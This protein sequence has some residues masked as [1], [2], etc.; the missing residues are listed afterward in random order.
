MGFAAG[1]QLAGSY[2]GQQAAEDEKIKQRQLLEKVLAGFQNIPL[3]D[4]SH[5]GQLDD[6]SAE[7]PASLAAQQEAMSGLGDIVKGGGLTLNDQA[8][9]NNLMNGVNRQSS[10]MMNRILEGMAAR[11]TGGSGQ[12]LAMQMQAAQNGTQRASD[13]SLQL[14]G[15]AK[16]RALDAMLSRGRLGGEISDRNLR[17]EQARREIQKFNIS[18]RDRGQQQNFNNQMA[19]QGGSASATG[20]LAGLHGANANAA[21]VSGANMGAGVGQIGQGIW[22]RNSQGDTNDGNYGYSDDYWRHS[23]SKLI[24]QED[25]K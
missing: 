3:P 12:E 16:K 2:L 25:D 23:P 6:L 21:A 9:Q 7:D 14:A 22:D 15:Q 1:A 17:R 5:P 10:A 20:P 4:Y 13:E 18:Q 24:D 11:G 19:R 8:A